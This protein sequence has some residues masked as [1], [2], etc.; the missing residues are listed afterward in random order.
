MP[1]LGIHH[2][3][4][5]STNAILMRPYVEAFIQS[6]SFF[7]DDFVIEGDCITPATARKFANTQDIKTVFIGYPKTTVNHKFNQLS[8]K[9]EGWTAKLPEQEFKRI[10]DIFIKDSIILQAACHN[11]NLPFIDSSDMT[12]ETIVGLTCAK[13]GL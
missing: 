12:I 11:Y 3:N 10:I 5:P 2:K 8:Q 4:T 1:E 6:R 9:H 7:N 13:L